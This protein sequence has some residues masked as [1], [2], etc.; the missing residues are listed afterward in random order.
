MKGFIMKKFFLLFAINILCLPAFATNWYQIGEKRYVDTGSI[1][2]FR[3]SFSS[4]VYTFWEKLLNDNSDFFK[5]VE[6]TEGTKVWYVLIRWA[7]DCNNANFSIL[8]ALPYDLNKK[9]L[10]GYK[11]NGLMLN[12]QSIPP[13][14]VMDNYYNWICIPKR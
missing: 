7:I 6:D 13:D 8:E 5:N 1:M 9:P 14:T 12:W 4:G 3:S 2:V 11:E 10:K